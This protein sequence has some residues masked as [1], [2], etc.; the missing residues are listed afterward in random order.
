MR[1]KATFRFPGLRIHGLSPI[2]EY[3]LGFEPVQ[4]HIRLPRWRLHQYSAFGGKG[5]GERGHSWARLL[6][7]QCQSVRSPGSIRADQ[8]LGIG[9][10]QT[11]FII[12]P[13]ITTPA[14]AYFQSAISPHS[15]DDASIFGA[16]KTVFV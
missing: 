6:R 13:S 9:C 8:A 15:P 14:V 2:E 1:V 5:S 10:L 12:A 7:P 3:R 11:C 4:T 16:F